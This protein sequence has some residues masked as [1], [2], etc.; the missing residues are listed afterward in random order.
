[1]TLVYNVPTNNT[2]I[3]NVTTYN[4]PIHDAPIYNTPIYN[5]PIYN[6]PIYNTPTYNIPIHNA[7][8]TYNI[9]IYNASTYN[10]PAYAMLLNT[11]LL[12]T[13]L[14]HTKSYRGIHYA[15]AMGPDGVGY[16]SYVD[17]VQVLVVAGSLHKNLEQHNPS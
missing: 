15:C 6:I 8:S 12:F 10:T 9:P 2:P 11:S 17:C 3:Y 7:P 1:M 4:T 16:V 13:M 14:L 5:A